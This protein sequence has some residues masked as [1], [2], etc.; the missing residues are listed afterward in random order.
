MEVG[1]SSYR[2]STEE[3]FRFESDREHRYINDTDQQVSFMTF[4]V[5]YEK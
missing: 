2:I 3:V 1:N 4:F 5:A